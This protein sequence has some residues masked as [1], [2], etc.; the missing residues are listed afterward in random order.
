MEINEGWRGTVQ[1][2][3]AAAL[4]SPVLCCFVLSGKVTISLPLPIPNN[5]VFMVCLIYEI[6]SYISP[7]IYLLYK[8]IKV[9]LMEKLYI[10][11]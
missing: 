4:L 8:T 5:L 3:S 10:L 9:S 11:L 6:F 7:E 1:A 2:I